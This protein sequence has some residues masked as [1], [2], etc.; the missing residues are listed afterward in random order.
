MIGRMTIDSPIINTRVK[1]GS[2]TSQLVALSLKHG[3]LYFLGEEDYQTGTRSHFVKIGI[4]AGDEAR[5]GEA[6]PVEERAD[7]D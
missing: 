3:W 2:D 6:E 7:P 5:N 4:T 1:E